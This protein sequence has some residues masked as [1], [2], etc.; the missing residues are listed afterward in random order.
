MDDFG[1]LTDLPNEVKI[2]PP[3]MNIFEKAEIIKWRVRQLDNGY[4]TT[5]EDV[6]KELNLT[7]S[8]SIATAE[9][10]RKKLPPYEIKRTLGDGSYEIWKHEDFE[11]F[12]RTK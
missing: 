7:D 1:I 5:I 12:P 6:V 11:F 8:Y 2:T 10:D 9:F 3:T 4:K